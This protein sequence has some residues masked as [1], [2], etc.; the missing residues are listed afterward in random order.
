MC[1][2]V[3]HG[4]AQRLYAQEEVDSP[5]PRSMSTGTW[6]TQMST[7]R[8][9]LRNGQAKTWAVIFFMCELTW[10]EIIKGFIKGHLTF[11]PCFLHFLEFYMWDRSY[12]GSFG[13]RWPSARDHQRAIIIKSELQPCKRMQRICSA[14]SRASTFLICFPSQCLSVQYARKYTIWAG[15]D[16]T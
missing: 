4:C 15:I 11:S 3:T 9:I 13:T 12:Q 8:T 5:P 2:G 16:V 6:F 7:F 1:S 14:I 10:T